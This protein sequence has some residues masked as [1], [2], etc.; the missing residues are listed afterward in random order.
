MISDLKDFIKKYFFFTKK[1]NKK[2]TYI[3]FLI[4]LSSFLELLSITIFLPIIE[5][6]SRKKFETFNNDF[7][8]NLLIKFDYNNWTQTDFLLVS[9]LGVVL[10]SKKKFFSNFKCKYFKSII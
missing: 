10:V 8:Q 2:I 7:I 5:V 1:F 9:L 6:F 3:F 4:F